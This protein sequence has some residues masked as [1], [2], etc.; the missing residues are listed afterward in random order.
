MPDPAAS[1]RQHASAIREIVSAHHF[2]NPRV[3][4]YDDPDYD[5]TLLLESV[6]DVSLF[7]IGRVMTDIEE[8]LAL[9]AF[10]ITDKDYDATV[11]RRNVR[12]PTSPLP[13]SE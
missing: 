4:D 8:K 5:V 6:G 2:T 12:P 7:D 13:E 3:V 10:V 11:K 9:K 1:L